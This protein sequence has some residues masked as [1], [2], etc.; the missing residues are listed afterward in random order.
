VNTRIVKLMHGPTLLVRPLRNGDIDTVLAVFHRL[1]EE[2]RRTR[3]NGA[4]A[5]LTEEELWALAR[6]DAIR[7]A[8]V[9]YV[10]GDP[11]PV[12]I[13][14]LVRDGQ[15][16]EIAFEVANDYQQRGIGTALTEELL[17]DARAAGITELTAPVTAANPAA[18]SLL[19]RAL[20]LLD[21]SPRPRT[22]DSRRHP[23]SVAKSSAVASCGS[24]GT[25][26]STGPTK[27]ERAHR[28]SNR[29][30]PTF[31]EIACHRT[32]PARAMTTRGRR[33]GRPTWRPEA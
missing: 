17:A 6:V 9:A 28:V 12:A 31:A 21:V 18:I 13:A 33:R 7:H 23:A 30:A 2:S 8:L 1:S 3:F 14:R 5:R 22:V 4:K 11:D 32:R 16:A 15:A 25:T 20:G 19:R 24:R 27:H 29:G 26:R 10:E